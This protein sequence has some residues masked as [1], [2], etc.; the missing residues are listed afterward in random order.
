MNEL[1]PSTNPFTRLEL[2]QAVTFGN[3]HSFYLEDGRHNHSIS[4]CSSSDIDELPTNASSQLSTK[5][6]ARIIEADPYFPAKCKAFRHLSDQHE[7]IFFAWTEGKP[8]PTLQNQLELS[9]MQCSEKVTLGR[10]IRRKH[11]TLPEGGIN[12][13]NDTTTTTTNAATTTT[14]TTGKINSVRRQ[15]Q[16]AQSQSMCFGEEDKY[17]GPGTN[18]ANKWH[19][20]VAQLARSMVLNASTLTDDSFSS[21]VQHARSGNAHGRKPHTSVSVGNKD[22]PRRSRRYRLKKS[23]TPRAVRKMI[24]MSTPRKLSSTRRKSLVNAL[25]DFGVETYD[26][27]KQ[28]TFTELRNERSLQIFT[29]P[30]LKR[31]LKFSSNAGVVKG[32]R[33]RSLH[34]GTASGLRR[35]SYGDGLVLHLP[36]TPTLNLQQMQQMQQR[37]HDDDGQPSEKE[38]GGSGG[39]CKKEEEAEEGKGKEEDGE[40]EEGEEKGKEA[41]GKD[42]SRWS[43][44][45]TSRNE[46]SQRSSGLQPPQAPTT[47]EKKLAVH[48]LAQWI[49][50]DAL[51]QNNAADTP[52]PTT[53]PNSSPESSRS[54]IET[55]ATPQPHR[56]RKAMAALSTPHQ[57]EEARAARAAV[58]KLSLRLKEED[59]QRRH[60]IEVGKRI[61]EE[62]RM[63]IALQQKQRRTILT[64]K[65]LKWSFVAGFVT[66]LTTGA[67]LLW[68]T[69]DGG[70]EGEE[71]ATSATREG[72]GDGLVFNG[73]YTP[74]L[75]CSK[76]DC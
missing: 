16:Y 49:Q 70:N 75:L 61:E 30:Q 62:R 43:S 55:E 64:K 25:L 48:Q 14:T 45:S 24:K 38:R 22:H 65:T 2:E 40:E 8:S 66:A 69:S 58:L 18:G 44:K 5:Q 23:A 37:A 28:F 15:L 7:E 21:F 53:A 60:A 19:H 11:N 54:S 56:Q 27:L 32:G 4:S 6:R 34:G 10:Y 17:G 63:L 50:T 57:Q 29:A 52:K 35:A 67:V 36:Q 9:P 39:G 13:E 73:T 42:E 3:V 31:M 68:F 12:K 26:D 59:A 33:R 47:T 72:E 74:T 46:Q 1:V 41:H 51:A 20:E 76:P 71:D